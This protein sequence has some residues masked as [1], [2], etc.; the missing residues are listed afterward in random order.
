MGA[1][2]LYSALHS[3][4]LSNKWPRNKRRSILG[5][6]LKIITLGQC[7]EVR[8]YLEWSV[9]SV[10][11]YIFYLLQCNNDHWNLKRGMKLEPSCCHCPPLCDCLSGSVF[12]TWVHGHTP[13]Y[14]GV[15][16]PLNS[17]L[18]FLG[19]FWT[20]HYLPLGFQD[21][22][23]FL[24][25]LF[26]TSSFTLLS[27]VFTALKFAMNRLL[28]GSGF[29]LWIASIYLVILLLCFRVLKAMTFQSLL[30]FTAGANL[31]LIL[32]VFPIEVYLLAHSSQGG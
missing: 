30:S 22:G 17:F 14:D 12:V 26:L 20:S 5:I 16:V 25:L 6:S 10:Q 21:L 24:S 9:V 8:A 3:N 29:F 32:K 2:R 19:V 15:V 28:L 1:H 13:S 4:Y 7:H 27:V 11:F 23:P 31:L 18:R